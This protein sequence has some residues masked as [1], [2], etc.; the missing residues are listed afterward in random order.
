ML[1]DPEKALKMALLK[2]QF[3]DNHNTE[4]LIF[5]ASFTQYQGSQTDLAKT[6]AAAVLP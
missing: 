1:E 4:L 3:F 2:Y 5:Y 6:K